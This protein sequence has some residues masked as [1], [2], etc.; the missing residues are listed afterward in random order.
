MALVRTITDAAL[1]RANVLATDQ[2]ASDA[3]ANDVL[4]R[5]NDW[6]AS[7]PTQGWV[8]TDSAGAAYTHTELD[9]NDTWPLDDRFIYGTKAILACLVCE[10]FGS[11]VTPILAADRAE[12]LA[13]YQRAFA[14]ATTAT[15]PRALR[16]YERWR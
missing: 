11:P 14:P 16:R 9:L 8:V 7:F 15:L 1:R 5:L 3:E 12:G 10:E 13:S 4:E 6:M 2:T